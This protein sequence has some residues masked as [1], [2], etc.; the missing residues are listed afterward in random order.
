MPETSSNAVVGTEYTDGVYVP[1]RSQRVA[2]DLA[3]SDGD[4]WEE[5]LAVCEGVSPDGQPRLIIRSFYRNG[6]SKERVWDEPPSGAGTVIHATSEMRKTAELERDELRLTLDMIPPDSVELEE[7]DK[8][9]PTSHGGDKKE[10]KGFFGRF[11]KKKEQKQVETAKD[12]NLQ[13]AI[14]Q[15][16][17]DQAFGGG[18]SRAANGGVEV[19]T[20]DIVAEEEDL[21]LAQALSVSLSIAETEAMRDTI[22][23]EEMFQRAL[24]RSR[25]EAL[26]A[27]ATGVASLPNPFEDSFSSF[28]IPPESNLEDQRDLDE[29]DRKLPAIPSGSKPPGTLSM[30][31]DPYG[32]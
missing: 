26:K 7:E 30:K 27:T 17:A 28:V 18:D 1:R 32:R 31:F 12:L 6:R 23:E 20:M 4:I 24:E 21:A 2:A 8:E 25:N 13:R 10:K 14:A 16:M 15:S 11:R 9:A 3:P 5:K 19:S 29:S 22:S